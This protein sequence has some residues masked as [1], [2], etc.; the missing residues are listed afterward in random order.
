MRQELNLT[1]IYFIVEIGQNHQGSLDIA[2]QM[3]DTLVGTG[4]SAIKTA[5]RDIDVCLTDQQKNMPYVN[6]NSF[7]KTYY[8]HRKALELTKDE[9]RELKEYIE[10]KGFDFISSFTDQNSL[11]FLIEIGVKFLKIASQRTTDISLLES[12]ALTN[13]PVII[14]TGMCDLK[15]VDLAIEIFS[16]NEKFLLQCTSIYPCEFEQINLNVLNTYKSRYSEKVNGFGFSGHHSGIAPDLAAY[17][18]GIDILER[19]FTLH[20]HWKGSDHAASLEIDG[21]KKILKYIE[22]M[23]RSIGSNKKIILPDEHR[24]IDKLRGDLN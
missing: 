4:V 21:I 24:A 20:R 9:Y 10:T 14:S 15:D 18:M 6:K 5:K 7:G 22:Q 17:M 13:K 8:E 11:D 2:K 1:D 19:H 12:T 16:N 23:N 3:V